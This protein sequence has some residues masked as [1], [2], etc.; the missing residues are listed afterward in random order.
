MDLFVIRIFSIQNLKKKRNHFSWAVRG[1]NFLYVSRG[2]IVHI[3]YPNEPSIELLQL[4]FGPDEKEEI[5]GKL[6]FMIR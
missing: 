6:V 5:F 1:E 4:M 3:I 2:G